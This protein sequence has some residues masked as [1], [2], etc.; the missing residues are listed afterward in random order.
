MSSHRVAAGAGLRIRGATIRLLRAH[1]ALAAAALTSIRRVAPPGLRARAYRSVSWPLARALSVQLDVPAV[2][3]T[4][5]VHTGDT[6]GCVVAV[7]G[8]WE[9]SITAVL[10]GVLT[11]G[12]VFVDVGAHIGYHTLL[13][14]GLVGEQG[15]VYAFEPSPERHADLVANL[16]RNAI[17]NVTAFELAG[18]ERESVGTLFLA[19]GTN[20]SASTMVARAAREASAGRERR[21]VRVVPVQDCI[22]G[23]DLGRVRVVKVDVEGFEIEV[24]RGLDRILGGRSPLAVVIEISPEWA[25]ESPGPFVDRLC[26]EHGFALWR[27]ANEYS[28]DAYFPT[29]PEPPY[30]IDFVPD[31]RADLILARGIDLDIP[32]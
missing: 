8:V 30:R 2:G 16:A 6:I 13:A 11:R 4:M 10:R 27:V 5:R 7:S 12:D 15:R 24:L 17:S 26:R 19:P 29:R 21:E 25:A 20:T 18:G 31:E 32:A 14:A 23:E 1:P 22:A 3:G 9:P 28:V